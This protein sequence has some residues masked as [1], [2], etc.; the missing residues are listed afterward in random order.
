MGEI[1]ASN[2]AHVEVT[3]QQ[4]KKGYTGL[5][6]KCINGALAGVAGVTCI[7]PIDLVKTRLQNQQV[8]D[9]RRMYNNLFDCF[10]KTAKADGIRGLYKGFGVNVTLI[11]PE[12]A[13]KLVGN[14]FF[15]Y[16]LRKDGAHLGLHRE[17]L[18]GG[19]AGLCQVIITTPMEMLKIQLQ[20][21]G[22]RI[23]VQKKKV[24]A[25]AVPD[26]A[27]KIN[28]SLTR[29]YSANLADVSPSAWTLARNLLQTEG[30]FGLYRGLGATLMRDVPF[31]M[32]Y[33][34]LFAH[35]NAMGVKR[36]NGRASF[37]HSFMCGCLAAT[38]ASLSVNPVDVIKTRLQLLQHAP[39]E[40]TYDGIRDCAT[41][42]W[43]Q[44]G[45]SAF[46]KGASCR[47]LVISP[48]FGIAQAVYYYG[49]GEFL[50]GIPKQWL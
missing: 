43:K 4:P 50:L 13:I 30:I 6:A 24:P 2:E 38:V 25:V 8:S 29:A 36:E 47:L 32:V 16:H 26:L 45:P 5:P 46:F 42:I 33:F 7:F 27:S 31:S 17:M 40:Q 41:K 20:D 18:A 21:A 14:D 22:R 19:G 15:R 3:N 10:I 34:P 35:L 49:V 1:S 28:P 12:K 48:L 44:E 9:G 11:S 39:G 37:K 23:S